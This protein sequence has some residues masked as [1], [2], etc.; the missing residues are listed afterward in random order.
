MDGLQEALAVINQISKVNVQGIISEI[1]Q[2][3]LELRLAERE[4]C[5]SV[6][7]NLKQRNKKGI[8]RTAIICLLAASALGILYCQFIHCL[9]LS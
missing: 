3:S 7:R 1:E 9:Y 2:S 4:F 8:V 5:K 6:V